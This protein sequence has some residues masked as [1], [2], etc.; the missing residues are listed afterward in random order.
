MGRRPTLPRAAAPFR[1]SFFS[2]AS[3]SAS[4]SS[5]SAS[6]TDGERGKGGEER[7]DDGRVGRRREANDSPH[8][9]FSRPPR[10]DGRGTKEEEEEEKK[11]GGGGPSAAAAVAA[12]AALLP[13][14]SMIWG[15]AIQ[16][17]L[18]RGAPDCFVQ[19]QR[20]SQ[21]MFHANEALRRELEA[22]CSKVK[23]L[24]LELGSLRAGV[25]QK[26]SAVS[27]LQ[28][29]VYRTLQERD[30]AAMDRR[31][32]Q[33]ELESLQGV[34][35]ER[36]TELTSLRSRLVAGADHNE[37]LRQ[38]LRQAGETI[39][40]RT[41]EVATLRS[42]FT[43]AD[44][45]RAS[46]RRINEELLREVQSLQE[47]VLVERKKVLQLA[48]E[49]QQH[50]LQ[51][52][53][54][55]RMQEQLREVQEK[56]VRLE[57]QHLALMKEFV[58]VSEKAMRD[59]REAL[60]AEMAAEKATAAHWEEA[61]KRLYQDLQARQKASHTLQVE[62]EEA[63]AANEG[64]KRALQDT[65]RQL[66]LDEQK[67]EVAWPL[68]HRITDPLP[69]AELERLLHATA[70][71]Q[72]QL[73]DTTGGGGAA[74]EGTTARGPLA[75]EGMRDTT[76][77]ADV[78]PLPPPPSRTEEERERGMLILP[79]DPT[80][81]DEKWHEITEAYA[82]LRV[83]L[84][85]MELTNAILTENVVHLRS[86]RKREVEERK[87]ADEREAV[88]RTMLMEEMD[89]TRFLEQQ[90]LSLRG[91]EVEPHARLQ[92]QG[93]TLVGEEEEERGGEKENGM[94]GGE[95]RASSTLPRLPESRTDLVVSPG[96]NVLELFLGQLV[97]SF[98]AVG[99]GGP[100]SS[101][102]SPGSVWATD[103]F[104][105]TADFLLHETI[106]SPTT[107]TGLQGFLNTTAAYCI[108]M[109]ALLL[110]YLSTR[111]LVVHLHR[112]RREEEEEGRRMVVGGGGGGDA[113][114]ETRAHSSSPTPSPPQHPEQEKPLM[115]RSLEFL[116]QMY[117]TVGEGR[118]CLLPWVFQ[119]LSL[120]SAQPTLRGH[121][122]LYRLQGDEKTAAEADL[123]VDAPLGGPQPTSS[124][125]AP[126]LAS[127]EF[128]VMARLPFSASFQQLA[129]EA[130]MAMREADA[131]A[132]KEEEED[133]DEGEEASTRDAQGA[134]E[135][136]P[137]PITTTTQAKQKKET[138]M[139]Y[140][141][142]EEL[143]A[144]E[145]AQCP[146]R[147]PLLAPAASSSSFSSVSSPL[148]DG[149]GYSIHPS[150]AWQ[151][152]ECRTRG[153]AVLLSAST[154]AAVRGEDAS[155]SPPTGPRGKT[156][157]A[158][159]RSE[160]SGTAPSGG[161]TLTADRPDSG[162]AGPPGRGTPAH[163][164]GGASSSSH[165]TVLVHQ[166]RQQQEQ[167]WSSGSA[168]TPDRG[169]SPS[170]GAGGD[171]SE[172]GTWANAAT[173][174]WY[175]FRS[176]PSVL[177]PPEEEKTETT[178]EAAPTGA[179]FPASAAA[180]GH[181][182]AGRSPPGLYFFPLRA[183]SLPPA[184]PPPTPLLLDATPPTAVSHPP[185]A[186]TRRR[187]YFPP[188]T[189]TTT[190]TTTMASSSAPS[191]MV[192]SMSSFFFPSATTPPALL[193]LAV[194]SAREGH[195]L[196]FPPAAAHTPMGPTP[197]P[198]GRYRPTKASV[199]TTRTT[200]TT[201]PASPPWPTMADPTAGRA[202]HWGPHGP[203]EGS[204]GDL[205]GDTRPQAFSSLSI[206]I[207]RVEL[208]LRLATPLPRLACFYE[209]R[210]LGREVRLPP[211]P[212]PRYTIE[213]PQPD[214]EAGTVW[215]IR[216]QAEY[217]ALRREA[218]TL[219]FLDA[220][221]PLSSPGTPPRAE[222]GGGG[223][224]DWSGAAPPLS[225]WSPMP[226][227]HGDSPRVGREPRRQR[228]PG[229]DAEVVW[230]MAMCE[231]HMVLDRPGVPFELELPLLGSAPTDGLGPGE[232]SPSRP[233]REGG[234][235][236]VRLEAAL[237]SSPPLPRRAVP[238]PS[239]KRVGSSMVPSHEGGRQ[240][241]GR[242]GA[243]E[244]TRV[245]SHAAPPAPPPPEREWEASIPV[246]HRPPLALLSL[247]PASE[248]T[249]GP[250]PALWS[251]SPFP[252]VASLEST[253]SRATR[254]TA[255]TER[256][257]TTHATTTPTQTTRTT[258]VEEGE[259]DRTPAS[260]AAEQT[261]PWREEEDVSS[262]PARDEGAAGCV[263]PTRLALS[264]PLLAVEKIPTVAPSL[265]TR[266]PPLA[267]TPGEGEPVG[268]VHGRTAAPPP[269]PP[270]T[271]RRS[272]EEQLLQMEIERGRRK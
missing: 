125:S 257:G 225:R 18:H 111:D 196:P 117:E 251:S 159:S 188:L 252:A 118:V 114:Q 8:H 245:P 87:A 222:R 119:E 197:S 91:F 135:G 271:L 71:H 24:E 32:T 44:S 5:S 259:E 243:G 81:D 98:A 90:I 248:P 39:E 17:A 56:N 267:P 168:A 185:R 11:K 236:R 231:L 128:R 233:V 254:T 13:D 34:M 146:T 4:S 82:G 15:D 261:L 130:L 131:S 171:T 262:R 41:A 129:K 223:G 241:E 247:P 49:I 47:Q 23:G 218:L 221:F 256:S 195:A 169:A 57:G 68:H 165:L 74:A 162:A 46:Q 152:T 64:L 115:E 166:G 6:W 107:T 127:L 75:E 145:T 124:A 62:R 89:R 250:F 40:E 65:R 95:G 28:E 106:V 140:S 26:E 224:D 228:S 199:A 19:L 237:P 100:P 260:P 181:G 102:L 164:G 242:G 189:T 80:T 42:Q 101:P 266:S 161:E 226:P 143:D 51:Q 58:E 173:P 83:D 150:A 126:P 272:I 217:A 198:F 151:T 113:E 212:T 160:T 172:E 255:T 180:V 138:P 258:M 86:E 109:D 35:A 235:V 55:E 193:S 59:A 210:A 190:T 110:Y 93:Q 158:P 137:P 123:V 108:R 203:Q 94:W 141:Y 205:W 63:R 200:T 191:S 60:Q 50:A 215:A 206:A 2:A 120:H 207:L 10:G 36:M 263:G 187:R 149:K 103:S 29:E 269:Q 270:S 179:T 121:V 38:A 136:P 186:E 104:F 220:D 78:P 229:E 144:W 73:E 265:P 45:G 153:E 67:L 84:K 76:T 116:E 16:E 92:M 69:R 170:A 249:P 238:P 30:M 156:G 209:L 147:P 176:F 52:P 31:A 246:D 105:I 148:R 240:S 7:Q 133:D 14:P 88:G 22:S 33:L 132:A 192:S 12:A 216:D 219:F 97:S 155:A 21:A 25:A 177:I 244:H 163:H 234:V 154:A 77:T 182:R 122:H 264:P 142:T 183:A 211:P 66:S 194:P 167:R 227:R 72:K 53:E 232:A 157:S 174:P 27:A 54:Q 43:C 214:G 204:G 61:A 184:P 139:P 112:V 178:T 1:P 3:A 213:Y 175:H 268:M 134:R 9:V 239:W 48:R 230:G 208:G 201:P 202:D 99:G 37:G 85:Q 79:V 253:T 96:E 70:A 20:A